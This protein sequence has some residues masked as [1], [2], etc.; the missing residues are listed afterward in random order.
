MEC[1]YPHMFITYKM[2]C[3]GEW[4][5]GWLAD[6]GTY[7]RKTRWIGYTFCPSRKRVVR[8]SCLW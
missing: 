4:V 6:L 1:V 2:R 7:V 3:V 8:E 5:G